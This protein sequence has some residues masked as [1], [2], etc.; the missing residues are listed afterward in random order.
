MKPFRGGEYNLGA[1]PGDQRKARPFASFA[2]TTTSGLR[3]L[4]LD[5][6][7]GGTPLPVRERISDLSQNVHTPGVGEYD[8]GNLDMGRI[9]YRPSASFRATEPRVAQR[10]APRPSALCASLCK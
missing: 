5:K 1:W 6:V 4:K 10:Y 3:A 2:S 8:L 9:D 7:A